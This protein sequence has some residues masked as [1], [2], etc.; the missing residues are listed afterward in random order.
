MIQMQC[1]KP[2]PYQGRQLIP[3]EKFEAE[4]ELDAH[5]FICMGKAKKAKPESVASAND[6]VA[7]AQKRKPTKKRRYR[8]RDMIAEE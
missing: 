8:R 6:V 4:N 2:V 5:V 7:G 1:V 3:G